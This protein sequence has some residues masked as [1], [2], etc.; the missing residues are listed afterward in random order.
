MLDTAFIQIASV[1][2]TFTDTEN[3]PENAIFPPAAPR[4][5]A[6]PSGYTEKGSFPYR[7]KTVSG[8]NPKGEVAGN[9]F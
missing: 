3:P 5:S 4:V 1:R 9:G 7:G 6:G 8:S 2:M